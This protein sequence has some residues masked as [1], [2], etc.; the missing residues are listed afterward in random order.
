MQARKFKIA[1]QMNALSDFVNVVQVSRSTVFFQSLR[2][3]S[4]MSLHLSRR[5]L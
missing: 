4:L 1:L 5:H 2:A 3:I